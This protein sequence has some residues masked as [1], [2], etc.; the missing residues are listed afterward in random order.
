VQILDSGAGNGDSVTLAGNTLQFSVDIAAGFTA[1]EAINL[2]AADPTLATQFTAQ[3]DRSTDTAND[4]TGNLAVMSPVSFSKGQNRAQTID[5]V[6]NLIN[7]DPANLASGPK[8]TARLAVVGNGIELVNDGPPNVGPLT[9]TQAGTS[10]AARD[11]G[12][13]PGDSAV[14]SSPTPGLQASTAFSFAGGNNNLVISAAATGT[15]LNGVTVHWADDGVAG[16][17]SASYN[18][19]TRVL[20]IDVDPATTT[21][22]NVVDLLASD[23]LFRAQLSTTDGGSPNTG[24]GML[25]AFPADQTLGGGTADVLTGRDTNGRKVEGIFS[26][27]IKLRE[28]VMSGSTIE[29]SKA[30]DALDGASLNLSFSRA[31]LG[32]RLKAIDALTTRNEAEDVTLRGALSNEIDVDF[33]AAVSEFASRQASLDASLQVSAQIA[34][35]TLLDYL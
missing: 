32:A 29:L 13:V 28:A 9:V 6:L 24:L 14:N 30:V 27:L 15:V 25:G 22:Q 21:A 5:D 31:E 8:V 33:A 35:S 20:T 4:G 7:N 16:N 3:L 26:A 17:N 12:L 19:T 1:Q 10:T 18:A 34:Q 2:L 23:P 11:L